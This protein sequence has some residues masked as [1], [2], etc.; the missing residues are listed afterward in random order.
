VEGSEIIEF[1]DHKDFFE[2]AFR[3]TRGKTLKEGK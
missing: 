1:E 2:Q 3:P